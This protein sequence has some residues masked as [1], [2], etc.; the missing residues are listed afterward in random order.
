VSKNLSRAFAQLTPAQQQAWVRVVLW[1]YERAVAYARAYASGSQPAWPDDLTALILREMRL[2]SSVSAD[3]LLI[4]GGDGFVRGCPVKAALN[5]R[6]GMT[7]KKAAGAV[8]RQ[9]ENGEPVMRP[10]EGEW[11]LTYT[12]LDAPPPAA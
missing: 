6:L 9:D 5:R 8:V 4:V 7:V 11:H 1:V 10:V 2:T 12:V 3:Y